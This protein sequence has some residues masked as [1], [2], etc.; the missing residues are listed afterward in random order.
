M[1]SGQHW[2]TRD[3]KHLHPHP[4]SA[5]L[6]LPPSLG[7]LKYLEHSSSLQLPGQLTVLPRHRRGHTPSRPTAPL[8]L[9]LKGATRY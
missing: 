9:T 3:Q 2:G 1:I 6:P 5:A 7:P 4:S 8:L